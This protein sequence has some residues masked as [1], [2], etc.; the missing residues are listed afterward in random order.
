MDETAPGGAS[1]PKG[2]ADRIRDQLLAADLDLVTAWAEALVWTVDAHRPPAREESDLQRLL[3]DLESRTQ[4]CLNQLG[5]L[6]I[7]VEEMDLSFAGRTVYH[8]EPGQRSVPAALHRGGVRQIVLRRGLEPRETRDLVGILMQASEHADQGPDDAVTL[9]WDRS[10]QHIDYTCVPLDELEDRAFSL[11]RTP[12]GG[13]SD[14]EIPWPIGTEEEM[15]VHASAPAPE[16]S[17]DWP[18]RIGAAAPWDESA[19]GRFSLTDVEA[20]NIRMVARIEEVN[21]PHGQLAEIFSMMLHAEESPAEF[22]E[23]ASIVGSLAEQAVASGNLE[24][25][26]DLLERL[27]AIAASKMTS[28]SEFQSATDQVLRSVG[29]RELLL[30]F[31]ATLKSRKGIDVIA[32]TRFLALLG[33]AAA[34]TVC[35]LLG[36][37]EDMKIRRALCEALAISCRNNVEVLLQRLS[38]PRWFVVRNILYVLGRIGHHGV[39]RAL[40]DALYHAD[41]RVRKEAVR[42][43][44]GIDSPTSRA[45]LNSALRDP[46][47]GVRILVAQMIVKRVDERA[48]QILWS[49]IESPEFAGRDADVRAAFFV[50]LG[51]AGADAL[52]PRLETILTR[53]GL[54]RSTPQGGREEAA[55]ALAWI[56]SAL[57]R[58]VLNREVSSGR[59][60][61]RAA[62][63]RALEAVRVASM[64]QKRSG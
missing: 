21:S 15:D 1:P 6:A 42:A 3:D 39:E 22:L 2:K 46:D 59:E 52:V 27:H 34:P 19:V 44:G 18:L 54:F 61:V 25:A 30:R 51:R 57:A 12:G 37:V 50:A 58:A 33:P 41:P 49:V 17:D 31:G 56:G 47:R 8:S 14:A 9:L 7:D 38:D 64:K 11:S 24:Q 40:G 23:T 32:I 10:F 16:R 62:V 53:G 20:E 60:E 26:G 45:H 35:D 48:A 55:L 5:E 4:A 43:L 29:R 63:E 36:E 13:G 28:R